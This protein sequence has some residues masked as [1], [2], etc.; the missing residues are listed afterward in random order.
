MNWMNVALIYPKPHGERI[1]DRIGVKTPPPPG[2][3]KAK[4]FIKPDRSGIRN[5]HLKYHEGRA[6]CPAAVE[7]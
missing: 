7:E 6:G 5:S 1:F 4:T 2:L 3:N